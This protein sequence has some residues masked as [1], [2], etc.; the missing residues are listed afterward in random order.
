MQVLADT[1]R[2]RDEILSHLRFHLERAQQC[3]IGEANKHRRDLEFAV[4]DM[5]YLKF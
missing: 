3:M 4:G 1:L 2:T 5:V